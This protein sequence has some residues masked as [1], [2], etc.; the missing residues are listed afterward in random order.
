MS[1]L[2]EIP[3][4]TMDF[5]KPNSRDNLGQHW[6]PAGDVDWGTLPG[7]KTQVGLRLFYDVVLWCNALRL[8]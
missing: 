8:K 7:Y 2:G 4:G 1:I 3:K 6:G 5:C